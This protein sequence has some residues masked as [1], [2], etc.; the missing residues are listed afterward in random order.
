MKKC[1]TC[2]GYGFVL[3]GGWRMGESSK[4]YCCDD[5]NSLGVRAPEPLYGVYVG[6]GKPLQLAAKESE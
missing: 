2:K 5:C 4:A 3:V 1:R 6:D